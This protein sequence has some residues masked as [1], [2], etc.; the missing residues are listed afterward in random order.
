VAA[1]P[2]DRAMNGER[3]T[4]RLTL[5]YDGHQFHGWQVQPDRRTVQGEVERALEV[6]LRHPIRVMCAGRTDAGVHAL[7]QV[8][9]ARTDSELSTGRILRGLN[10][11]LPRDVAAVG[12]Q[13][14][15]P[16]F[17]PRYDATGKHYRYRI[18][19]RAGRP[20]LRRNRCWHLWGELDVAAMA[21]ALGH[22][23]GEHDF[24][25]FRAADCPNRDPVKDLR[26]AAIRVG[27][28]PYLDVDLVGSGFL[29]HM[30]RVVIGTVV[31]VGQGRRAAASMPALLAGRDRTAAGRTAP[32][33]GLTL[34]EVLYGPQVPA[35]LGGDAD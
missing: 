35:A 29:K 31:E 9:T 28:E 33:G 15:S 22:L 25:A 10:G 12:V 11:I 23:C 8:C 16:S 17:H 3:R 20:V 4:L 19:R 32:A 34:V 24:S 27:G 6:L 30:V 1:A 7:A 21:E 5:E 14:A 2:P 13:D 26:V 18:L